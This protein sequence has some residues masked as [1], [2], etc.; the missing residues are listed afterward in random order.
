MKQQENN[1]LTNSGFTPQQ[2]GF[3]FIE[4]LVVIVIIG[5][6]LTLALMFLSGSRTR[7]RDTQRFSDIKTVQAAIELYIQ[8]NAQK[9][10][11]G[12]GVDYE[13]TDYDWNDL[14]TDLF[15]YL[16][17]SELPR[18]PRED[19]GYSYSYCAY[20]HNYLLVAVMENNQDI[21]SDI[22]SDPGYGPIDCTSNTL[23]CNDNGLGQLAG[24]TGSVFCTGLL[25]NQ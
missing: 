15:P 18:D 9:L 12:L 25:K 3:T 16:E 19:D 2:Q 20:R 21:D 1:N 10:P 4:M 17:N 13:L 8:N 11:P 6:L 14:R 7:A 24:K 5:I 23:D 22:D